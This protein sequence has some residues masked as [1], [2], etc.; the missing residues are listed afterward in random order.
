MS[1][2][3]E[4]L[5]N[6]A[7]IWVRARHPSIHSLPEIARRPRRDKIRVGYFSSD[8][9][10]HALSHLMAEMFE[11][12][13][14][15]RFEV[16]AFSFAPPSQTEIQQ[17]LRAA[18]DRFVD[19]WDLLD[20][21]VTALARNAEIDI[22]VDL[23]G[24][25]TGSR[26]DIFAMRAA[27][28]QVSYMGYAGTMGADYIDYLI[29]DETVIPVPHQRHYTEKIGYMPDTYF[30]RDTRQHPPSSVSSRSE[31]GLPE[32]GFV[33]CC[34]NN[35]QKI[36]PDIFDEWMRILKRVPNSV[37]WLLEDNE[38]AADNLRKE[39]ESRGV[40]SKRLVFAKRTAVPAHL[41]RHRLADLF[42]DTLP[43]NGHTTASDALWMGLPVLTRIGETFAG[44]VA[45][46]LL[47]AAGLPELITQ[48]PEAY[49]TL[50]VEIATNPAKLGAIKRKLADNRLATAVFDVSLFTRHMEAAY[51]AMVSRYQ[52]GLPPDHIHLPH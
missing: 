49:E 28:I 42:L 52:A 15:S 22:A 10:D 48:T 35:N 41:A 19:V 38:I 1:N 17:R 40:D 45:A 34:F 4:R 29:A 14:R 9:R 36:R 33:F 18:F 24:F 16:T 13:D 50:A 47:F 39:S 11:R 37:L 2:S 26:T 27:P 8:F 51:V 21:D 6:A 12:H 31:A 43:F 32:Q 5:R 44:R 3:P 46:S 23:N 25:T 7:E 20:K 30:V